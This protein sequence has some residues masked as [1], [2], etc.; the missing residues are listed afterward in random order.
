MMLHC[1]ADSDAMSKKNPP[2]VKKAKSHPRREYWSQQA[3]CQSERMMEA[4][5]QF[6]SRLCSCSSENHHVLTH[7]S[8]CGSRYSSP[9]LICFI[10]IAVF[11]QLPFLSSD[12]FTYLFNVFL[13]QSGKY[14]SLCRF[15]V[16][17]T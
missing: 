9:H 16:M 11:Y 14:S 10:I 4:S 13:S 8:A 15:E 12:Y 5:V 3:V 7:C 17:V 6:P 2:R 1:L